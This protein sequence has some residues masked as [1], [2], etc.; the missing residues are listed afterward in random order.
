MIKRWVGWLLNVSA[1]TCR[2]RRKIKKRNLFKRVWLEAAVN[3]VVK[4]NRLSSFQHLALK[5]FVIFD[6]NFY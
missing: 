3:F 1:N 6:E 5:N 2:R 4:Q